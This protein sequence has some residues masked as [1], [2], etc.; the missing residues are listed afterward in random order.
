MGHSVRMM[1]P[2]SVKP[3]VKSNKND[4]VDAESIYEAVQRPNMCFI[5]VKSIEQQYIQR[6]RRI[7]A[8]LKSSL[9]AK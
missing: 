9:Q 4:A 1:A 7:R 8:K 2:Q 5:P 3:Y 6:F